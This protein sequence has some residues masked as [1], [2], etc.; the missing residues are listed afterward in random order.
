VILF[1][2][3]HATHGAISHLFADCLS[4]QFVRLMFFETRA[5]SKASVT[6]LA[7]DSFFGKHTWR[8][9]LAVATCLSALLR[10][11]ASTP[12]ITA[13]AYIPSSHYTRKIVYHMMS[14]YVIIHQVNSFFQFYLSIEINVL[15]IQSSENNDP[16]LFAMF[17][18]PHQLRYSPP[19]EGLYTS[20]RVGD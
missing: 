8:N 15:A 19:R 11:A 12:F 10:H 17:L 16:V 9:R 20:S 18:E 13:F 1:R 7:R 2:H 14:L 3:A 4:F 5:T 6:G